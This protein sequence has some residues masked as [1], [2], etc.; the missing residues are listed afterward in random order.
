MTR[1]GTTPW[2]RPPRNLVSPGVKAFRNK[3]FRDTMVS[4]GLGILLTN[5]EIF[6]PKIEVRLLLSRDPLSDGRLLCPGLS[7]TLPPRSH[8]PR[9]NPH[10]APQR[11]GPGRPGDRAE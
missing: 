11:P 8:H 1:V 3:N 9:L 4:R 10:P 6:S 7:P 5:G 2:C